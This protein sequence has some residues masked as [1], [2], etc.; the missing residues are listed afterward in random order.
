MGSKNSSQYS[1]QSF[2]R[3]MEEFCCKY[4]LSSNPITSSNSIRFTS[5]S[6]DSITSDDPSKMWKFIKVCQEDRGFLESKITNIG[7]YKNYKNQHAK[8]IGKF[9][10]SV[11]DKT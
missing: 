5:L 11:D 10:N 8:I 1:S 9:R 7:I 6:G 2:E 4:L 3:K